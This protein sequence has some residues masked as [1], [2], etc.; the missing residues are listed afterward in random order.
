MEEHLTTYEKET[1]DRMEQE[2]KVIEE[3]LKR[4]ENP[5]VGRLFDEERYEHLKGL[6]E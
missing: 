4:G 2:C 6:C 5:P 3:T 1:L